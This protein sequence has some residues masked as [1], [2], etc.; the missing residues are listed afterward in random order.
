MVI[1]ET[2]WKT[3]GAGM[4]NEGAFWSFPRIRQ[5]NPKKPIHYSLKRRA[6]A[7]HFTMQQFG[8]ILIESESCSHIM[9]FAR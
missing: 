3:Q 2:G 5:A 6:R 1:A 7:A 9:M 4:H 8:N